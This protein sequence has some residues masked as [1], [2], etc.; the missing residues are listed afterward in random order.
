MVDD[1]IDMIYPFVKLELVSPHKEVKASAMQTFTDVFFN[2]KFS[3]IIISKS[4]KI[5]SFGVLVFF[6]LKG[7]LGKICISGLEF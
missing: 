3:E 6:L 2:L 1:Q 7:Q 5:L 4:L